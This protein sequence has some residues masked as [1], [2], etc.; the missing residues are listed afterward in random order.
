MLVKRGI[1]L[2]L[3]FLPLFLLSPQNGHACSC[4]NPPTVQKEYDWASVVLVAQMVSVEKGQTATTRDRVQLTTMLVEKV[5]KGPIK[6]NEQMIFAQGGGADC[7]WTFSEKDIGQRYLFYLREDGIKDK[8]SRIWIASTCGRSR[9]LE[10][11]ADDLL[12]LENISKV[13]GKTRLSG[14]LAF[15]ERPVL[16]GQEA[17]SSG[18]AGKKVRVVG[19]KKSYE[20]IT[21]RDGVYEM[22]D[23]P[24]GRYRIEPEIPSAWRIDYSYASDG[25]PRDPFNQA[26][27]VIIEAEKHGYRNFI[28]GVDNTIR[29]RVLNPSG[30]AMTDVCV[31]LIPAEGKASRSFFEMGCTKDDG[32]FEITGVPSGSYVIAA[33]NEGKISSNEPFRTVYYPNTL[34][35]EKAAVINVGVG[36]KLEGI[37]ILVPKLEPF[38]TVDGT[39]LYSDGKPVVGGFVEFKANEA[40]DGVD[41]RSVAKTDDAGRFSIK[42]LKRL[43][44]KLGAEMSAYP[45]KFVNCA[46]IERLIREGGGT[47]VML[48]TNVVDIRT[49]HNLTGVEL[50]YSFTGCALSNTPKALKP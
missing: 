43:T 20:L 19:E 38:I 29:G 15:Y 25:S 4:A 1:P 17:S 45:G 28:Y 21:N 30:V 26:F 6:F 9:R 37:D 8:A 33:N 46:A 47:S 39:L 48:R 23:L 10:Y 7:I 42:I 31:R 12:Y 41:G 49:E 34:E 5:F 35:R 44:G 40:I 50:R 32:F 27:E 2:T 11:T 3:W 18:L 24:P 13:R 22:Y 16:E 36:H 14:T